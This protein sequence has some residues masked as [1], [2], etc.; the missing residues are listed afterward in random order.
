MRAGLSPEKAQKQAEKKIKEEEKA[1]KKAEEESQASIQQQIAQRE[2]AEDKLSEQAQNAMAMLSDLWK[3]TQSALGN[4]PT[5]GSILFPLSILL[6]FFFL[7]LPVNGHTRAVWLWLVITGQ[8]SIAP[9][10]GVASGD[11]GTPST[12]PATD[13]TQPT[14]VGN[15]LSVLPSHP[16]AINPFSGGTFAEDI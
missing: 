2:E 7:L 13:T 16:R 14:N 10:G 9:V 11:F 5:Y 12:A 6:V 8:A 1:Q 3:S 15:F 4:I